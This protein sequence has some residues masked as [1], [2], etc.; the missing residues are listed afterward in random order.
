MT[1][2][3]DVAALAGVSAMTVSNVVNGREHKVSE[4]TA[5][6]VRAA[7]ETLGYVPNAQARA[8]AGA[9][10]RIVALVYDYDAPRPAL[11]SSHESAFVRACEQACR[12]VEHSLML[13]GTQDADGAE[14][15]DR[16]RAW[17]PAGVIVL[18]GVRAPVRDAL[19][20]LEAPVVLIDA[21]GEPLRRPGVL[22]VN[23]DDLEGGH[24][25]GRHLARLGHREIAFVGPLSV[26]SPVISSRLAGL[27]QAL[28]AAGP[29]ALGTRPADPGGTSAGDVGVELVD[30]DGGFED[31]ART[32]EALGTR[33]RAVRRAGGTGVT[34]VFVTEDVLAMGL[35]AGLRRCGL[36]VPR[37]VSVVG[38]DGFEVST[39][40]D[41]P[42]A[43]VCQPI[44][45]KAA[46]AV[47]LLTDPPDDGA[48]VVLPVTWRE[49]GTLASAPHGPEPATTN[50]R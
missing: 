44:G 15:L 12:Q 14:L 42:L 36:K 20:G 9:S 23:I 31:G 35:V 17:S 26:G 8:L 6:R 16:L 50:R 13:C 7:I 19:G 10:S 47:E 11:A 33:I 39:Y 22:A 25:A 18:G 28:A 4:P 30:A 43:T 46:C 49:G 5:R 34:G 38:F 2:L 27:R 45:D 1:T 32:G 41:P 21:Y 40:C 48:R 29:D 24:L 37:D 3:R